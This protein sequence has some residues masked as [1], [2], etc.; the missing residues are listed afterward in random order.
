MNISQ[1]SVLVDGNQAYSC[2]FTIV[3]GRDRPLKLCPSYTQYSDV[4]CA[5][6]GKAVSEI[7]ATYSHVTI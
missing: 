3:S 7:R 2:E 5:S 4:T 1:I 6:V